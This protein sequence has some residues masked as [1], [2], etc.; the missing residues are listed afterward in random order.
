MIPSVGRSVG[1]GFLG[2][3]ASLGRLYGVCGRDLL[4]LG[5]VVVFLIFF[6][7]LVLLLSFLKGLIHP[8]ILLVLGLI[9]L[10]LL[11]MALI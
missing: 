4:D 6:L 8:F 10:F 11:M 7:S 1:G 2:D 3:G 9:Q 5:L